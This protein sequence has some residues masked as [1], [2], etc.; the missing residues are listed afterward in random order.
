MFGLQANEAL[1]CLQVNGYAAVHGMR[2]GMIS[3]LL[4]SWVFVM[5]GCNNMRVSKAFRYD[6]S[7]PTVLQV[8]ALAFVAFVWT[9]L[10]HMCPLTTAG[11]HCP[12]AFVAFVWTVLC[13]MCPLTTAG[14]HCP[15]GSLHAVSKGSV[16]EDCSQ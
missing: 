6:A 2:Y 15:F 14:S 5:D 11:S 7:A 12:F 4:W 8:C 13:H 10:C 1:I 9:V 16:D 3:N